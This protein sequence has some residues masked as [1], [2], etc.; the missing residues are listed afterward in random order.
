MYPLPRWKRRTCQALA[1]RS[2]YLE[3]YGRSHQ[4][5]LVLPSSANSSSVADLLALI[6][7]SISRKLRKGECGRAYGGRGSGVVSVVVGV[8]VVMVV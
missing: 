4:L 1:I 3:N 6:G 5:A 2:Q 7:I 8:V